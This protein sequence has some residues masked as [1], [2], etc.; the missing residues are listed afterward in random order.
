MN[1]IKVL[2]R[3]FKKFSKAVYPNLKL[4]IK[5]LLKRIDKS[6]DSQYALDRQTDRQT[7]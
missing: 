1:T 7:G 3:F 5:N 4:W 2:H 6:C